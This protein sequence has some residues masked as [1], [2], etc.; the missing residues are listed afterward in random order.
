MSVERMVFA[1]KDSSSTSIEE[2]ETDGMRLKSD[3]KPTATTMVTGKTS[4]VKGFHQAR[5]AAVI[6]ACT[7][8]QLKNNNKKKYS[9]F[10]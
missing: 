7:H 1:S 4:M 8:V 5:T 6:G 9:H 10:G 3:G 2:A